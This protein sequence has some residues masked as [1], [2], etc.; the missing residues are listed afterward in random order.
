MSGAD[1]VDIGKWLNNIRLPDYS[2]DFFSY[3]RNSCYRANDGLAC[4][5]LPIRGKDL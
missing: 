4:G 1:I 5:H 2:I 3:L